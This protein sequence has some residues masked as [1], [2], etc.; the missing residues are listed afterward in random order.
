MAFEER[1]EFPIQDR[2]VGSAE[3]QLS[4][5]RERRQRGWNTA[6]TDAWPR[7]DQFGH[8]LTAIGN[9]HALARSNVSN[10]LAQAILQFSQADAFHFFN[11]AP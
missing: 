1:C 11:V 10:I 2:I 7:R 6:F 3:R 5:P 9:E 4:P 8:N